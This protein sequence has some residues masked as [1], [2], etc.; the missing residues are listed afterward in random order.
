MIFQFNDKQLNDLLVGLYKEQN[1]KKP[2]LLETVELI[3]KL[4]KNIGE[5]PNDDKY[6]KIK[7][8]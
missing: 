4:V 6:K 5:N 3:S 7:R 8:V 2:T 1:K